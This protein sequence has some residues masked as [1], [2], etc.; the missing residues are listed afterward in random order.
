MAFKFIVE[1][2]RRLS[3]EEGLN[4]SEIAEKIGCSKSTV[5]RCRTAN[6]IPKYNLKNRKDKSYVCGKCGKTVFIARCQKI[7]YYCEDC[8]NN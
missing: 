7:K 4:D 3:Q 2:I 8:K 5:C 6:N 1:E